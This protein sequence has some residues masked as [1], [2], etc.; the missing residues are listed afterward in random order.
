MGRS[1]AATRCHRSKSRHKEERKSR[2]L[3]SSGIGRQSPSPQKKHERTSEKMK[4]RRSPSTSSSSS[5]SSI[6]SSEKEA[7]K[8]KKKKHREAKKKMKH[9]KKKEKREKKLQKK[10]SE[11]AVREEVAAS[12]QTPVSV[13]PQKFLQ[14]WQSEESK[15]HGPV[16][17]DEQMARLHTKRPLTKEEYEA[18]QSVIRRVYDSETGR[19]R[20]IRGDGEILEEIVSQ[21]RHKEINKVQCMS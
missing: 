18:R 21:E 6:S 8:K 10:L 7:K 3:S 2:S 13:G 20:L 19:T 1:E 17:T 9:K 15:E 11:K 16:M 14:T 12:V 4:R 5:S